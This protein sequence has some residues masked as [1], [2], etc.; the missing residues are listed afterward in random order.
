MPH[1][2]LARAALPLLPSPAASPPPPSDSARAARYTVT[3]AVRAR[4]RR[5][6][7][8]IGSTRRLPNVHRG[9]NEWNGSRRCPPGN[10]L[11]RA[12]RPLARSRIAATAQWAPLLE[13]TP[14]GPAER[15]AAAVSPGHPVRVFLAAILSG[16]AILLGADDRRRL[17][18]DEGH[19]EDRRR[20]RLGRARQP[21]LVRERTGTTRRSLVGRLDPRRRARD[22]GPRRGA[23][24]RVPRSRSTGGSPRSRCS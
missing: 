21:R 10:T 8:G 13:P 20:R 7:K 14:G 23:A 15:F 6:R 19:P 9:V 3:P 12:S 16:Y 17:P 5:T 2:L 24:R 4:R 22:P 1:G 11:G 18:P